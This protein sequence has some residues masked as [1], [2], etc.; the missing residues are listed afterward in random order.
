[1][2]PN[3]YL[4]DLDLFERYKV[5][6][7][8]QEV[9]CFVF[10]HSQQSNVFKLEVLLKLKPEIVLMVLTNPMLFKNWH[11]EIVQAETKLNILS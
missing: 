7:S 11:P 4:S 9:G 6:T 1:M 3:F 10:Q 8:N 2:F 5:A